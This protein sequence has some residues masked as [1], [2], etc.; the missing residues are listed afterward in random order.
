MF[1]H[2]TVLFND[3]QKTWTCQAHSMTLIVAAS[4]VVFLTR[5][6]LAVVNE[7]HSCARV[8]VTYLAADV[9]AKF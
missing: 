3:T 7:R 2:F 5:A 6:D 9:S 8:E 4:L 1:G